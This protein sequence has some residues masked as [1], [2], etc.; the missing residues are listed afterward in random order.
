M[1]SNCVG[2]FHK[3]PETIAVAAM[4]HPEKLRWF[5]EQEKKKMGVWFDSRVT[6]EEIMDNAQNYAKEVYW[7][8]TELGQTCD[9]GG[10]TD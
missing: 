10:C 4:Q 1:I 3:K 5:S 7:E 9:S 6:Y 2:C 8:M